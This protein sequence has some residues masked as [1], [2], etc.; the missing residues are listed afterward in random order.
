MVVLLIK[1]GDKGPN[2]EDRFGVNGGYT[3]LDFTEPSPFFPESSEGE[4]PVEGASRE[5]SEELVDDQGEPVLEID[6][7]RF[8][9]IKAGTDYSRVKDGSLPTAYNGHAAELTPDEL[10]RLKT[11][12]LKLQTDYEYRMAVKTKSRGEVTDMRRMAVKT[13]SRGE[14]TDMRLLGLEK[15][16]NLSPEIF[17]HVHELVALKILRDFTNA[18]EVLRELMMTTSSDP[19]FSVLKTALAKKSMHLQ[20]AGN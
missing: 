5:L 10:R 9:H 4:Q 3:N 13:K 16:A 6:P 17:T 18:V 20:P 14:V 19:R 15:A 7:A 8:D 11:H 1:R 2:G 12:V